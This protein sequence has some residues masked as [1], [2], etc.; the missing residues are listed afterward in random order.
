MSGVPPSPMATS[1]DRRIRMLRTA[2]GPV[3]AAALDDPD[4][5]E[6]ML[7][8]DRTL[9]IDRL[10]S[11]RAPL[12]VELS[13]ADGERI[14]RLVAAH[15]GAE[16]HR[17]QPLLTAELPETGERFEGILPP[18]APAPAFALRKRAVGVIPLARYVTDGMM[19]ADQAEFLVEVVR[20]RQNILIAGGTST[21]KTTLANA[22]L[23]EIAATGDRVL[24]LEDTVELQCAAR[25]HVPLR[26]RQG[27]V[28]M[29][30]LVRSSMRLRPDR[31]V[32]GEVR[33]GEA[34]DLIKVWGT[35]HP[36]GIATIHAGSALGAL[37]RLEQLILE[38]A[39]HPPRALIA[40]AVNVVIHIAGR[41]RK[42]RIDS[43][44]RVIGFDASSYQLDD[45]LPPPLSSVSV[46]SST[47]PGELP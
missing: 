19:T 18:A 5:V 28:S 39:V 8:P 42:R 22:L 23:A 24:V 30:E 29:Q 9:W 4:V 31:V 45:A 20:E 16:V 3:I 37:L 14:I 32:V 43:I 10:S 11:G 17:G 1:L 21:G 12:G 6:I 2:M 7:N 47:Q 26:T 44:A 25:D 33:G 27:V 41:G 46:P 15:V 35:G 40:E 34:L 38:V 36:G 13:E